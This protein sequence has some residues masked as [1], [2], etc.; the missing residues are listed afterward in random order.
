MNFD[1]I[2]LERLDLTKE[3]SSFELLSQIMP[4]LSIVYK[5]KKFSDSEDYKDSN[6]VVEIENGRYKVLD[7]MILCKTETQR[8]LQLIKDELQGADISSKNDHK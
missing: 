7:Q 8:V 2:D 1:K 5:T 3:V 6:N 4:P